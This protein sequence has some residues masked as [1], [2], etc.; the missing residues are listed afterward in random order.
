MQQNVLCAKYSCFMRDDWPR[1]SGKLVGKKMKSH[2][3]KASIQKQSK[4]KTSVGMDFEDICSRKLETV[5]LSYEAVKLVV[6]QR[7]KLP[8]GEQSA[9]PVRMV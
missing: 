4:W 3:R 9:L 5:A 2:Q 6:S 8:A 7:P 1:G